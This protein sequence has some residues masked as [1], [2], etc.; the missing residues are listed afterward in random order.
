MDFSHMSSLVYGSEMTYLLEQD[1]VY[2]HDIVFL[3][4]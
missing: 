2:T 1:T 3:Q 4:L